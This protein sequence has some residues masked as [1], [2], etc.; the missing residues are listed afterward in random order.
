M[1]RLFLLSG[2]ALFLVLMG[3]TTTLGQQGYNLNQWTWQGASGS[4]GDLHQ[5]YALQ[6]TSGQAEAVVLSGGNYTLQAGFWQPLPIATAPAMVTATA[7]A[8]ST[9]SP[10]TVTDEVYVSLTPTTSSTGTTEAS[11]I[12]PAPATSS[13]TASPTSEVSRGKP[14]LQIDIRGTK[15]VSRGQAASFTLTYSNTGSFTATKVVITLPLPAYTAFDKTNS[16]PGWE[17]T[18]TVS[19]QADKLT[20]TDSVTPTGETYALVVGDLAPGQS[21]EAIFATIVQAKVPTGLILDVESSIGESPK[22]T[23][24]SIMEVEVVGYSLYIPFILR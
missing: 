7:P 11:T 2:S 10:P 18:K 20:A 24:K 17:L 19:L 14:K 8:T 13:P 3:I 23:A 9:P 16:T 6:G 15:Q 21:G 22:T 5:G 12:T 4:L 1:K